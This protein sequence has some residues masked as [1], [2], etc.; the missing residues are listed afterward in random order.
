MKW[1]KTRNTITKLNHKEIE[2]LDRTITS[3]KIES[4]IKKSFNNNKKSPGPAGITTEFY[5]VLKEEPARSG[6]SC[7]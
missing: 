7:L 4:V 3:K 6:G 5:Q 2:N 1:I